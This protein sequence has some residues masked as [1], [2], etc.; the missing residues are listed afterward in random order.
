MSPRLAQEEVRPE[1]GMAA[2]RIRFLH[3]I[4]GAGRNWRSVARRLADGDPAWAGVLVDL[5]LH[6]DSVG[7]PP[8]HTVAAC[9]EDVI[10]TA[11]ATG[12]ARTD[13][14]LGHSFGGKVALEVARRGPSGLRQAWIIDAPLSRREPGG[15]AWRMLD[16]LRRRQGPFGDREE[17][18][19]A[20]ESEGYD[21]TVAR[22]MATNL[23]ERDEGLRWALNLDGLEALLEDFFRVD[24]WEVVENPP[25]GVEIQVVRA[26]DSDVLSEEACRRVERA[27]EENGRTRLHRLPGGHWLNVSNPEGLIELMKR[28]LPR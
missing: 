27:G 23:E 11:S 25:E 7:F 14:V 18:V 16:V 8:P 24:A 6:G 12:T 15:T 19:A 28:R 20:L 1:N 22:W 21:R 2:G 9:A 26:E 17:A 5:R 4:F 13:V 10:E 3:G